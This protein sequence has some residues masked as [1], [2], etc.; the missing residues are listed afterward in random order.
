MGLTW[1]DLKSDEAPPELI[2][3][4]QYYLAY[5][6]LETSL[7]RLVAM[8]IATTHGYAGNQHRDTRRMVEALANAMNF[9]GM[10]QAIRTVIEIRTQAGDQASRADMLESWRDLKRR[11]E[12]ERDL[13]NMFAHSSVSLEED[14]GGAVLVDGTKQRTYSAEELRKRTKQIDELTRNIDDLSARV[15]MV[16]FGGQRVDSVRA[17]DGSAS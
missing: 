15:F 10:L 2:E 4:A 1:G 14:L 7:R 16:E 6:E 9:H 12:A 5:S 3:L 17:P 8:A 13:R 11:C